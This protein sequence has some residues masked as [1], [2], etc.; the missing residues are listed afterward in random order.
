MAALRE[1]T[2]LGRLTL[3]EFSE[4]VE[5][6]TTATTLDELDRDRAGSSSVGSAGASAAPS[7][8]LH[9]RL[10][11]RHRAHRTLAAAE[12]QLRARV[13]GQRRPR[14]QAGR[15]R[16]TRRSSFTAFMLFGN[17]DLYVP[18]GV[19]GG[20]R[21]GR[22]DRAPPGARPGRS[23]QPGAPLLRAR[24]FSLFGTADLWRVPTELGGQDLQRRSCGR[25]SGASTAELPRRQSLP[26][27]HPPPDVPLAAR[28][29]ARALLPAAGLGRLDARRHG[30]RVARR[31]VARWEPVLEELDAP[32]ARIVVTHFHPDHAGGGAD[33]Q[34]LTGAR[35][36]QGAHDYD[37]CEAVWGSSDWSERL[38]DY[39]RAHGLPEAQANE[40]RTSRG[41]SR[42]SSATPATRSAWPKGRGRR[43]DGA[44]AARPRGRAHLPP[45]RRRSSSPG[46]T[47]STK[48]TPDRRPL[49]GLPPGPARRLSGLARAHDR[50][51]A[52]CCAPGPRRARSRTRSRAPARSS[53]TTGAA[54]T[55]RSRRWGRSLAA[56]TRCRL[57]SS[58]K[59]STPAAAASRS[60]RRSRAPGTACSRR[61]RCAHWRRRR[62][63]Y[64]A[65]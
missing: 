43:L 26:A 59:G 19:E 45:A 56:P 11:Q 25:R 60:P 24:I 28:D 32:V 15:A 49:S 9:R 57:R 27:G 38:A 16:G 53:S 8:A 13:R 3:E 61:A 5:K 33:A 4:R 54:S 18:E 40:L 21:R 34:A 51:G 1:H 6:A 64:T 50:A 62:R 39:L 52:D 48:I 29:R 44:R 42:L 41:S 7:Q 31:R 65:A 2:A 55:R 22:R 58:A 47:C 12:V 10:L 35:V 37:Q 23:P 17:I 14:P 46:I 36:L 63:F 20:L 30:S